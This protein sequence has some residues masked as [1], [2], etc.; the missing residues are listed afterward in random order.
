M[1]LGRVNQK[2]CKNSQK[3]QFCGLFREYDQGRYRI[4]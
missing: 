3:W 1:N 2:V 4:M